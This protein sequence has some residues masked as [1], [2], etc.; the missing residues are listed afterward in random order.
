MAEDKQTQE[1]VETTE[2]TSQAPTTYTQAQ[3]DSEADKRAAKALETAKAKW[4]AEQAKA[5]EE[6]KSE[7]AR[8]AKMTEDEKA[9]EIEKQRQ[10]EL[11]KREAELNQRELSTS[12]KSLLVDKG[13]PTDFAGSLVALGDAD[14]IK[15]AVENIQKTIQETVNK[16]VEAKLQT[17]SPKNGA[18]AIDGA[19][20]PFKKIMSQYKKK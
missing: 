4:E 13:L 16:Q 5:L 11:D 12:T 19:N 1:E 7:G 17:D 18:S 20:D 8:L 3:L 10:A 15:M 2:T 14:K 6:A 9:K